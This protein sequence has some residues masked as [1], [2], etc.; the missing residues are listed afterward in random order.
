MP[1]QIET[2]SQ[3]DGFDSHQKIPFMRVL[4]ETDSLSPELVI[5]SVFK[6]LLMLTMFLGF[7]HNGNSRHFC[8][9]FPGFNLT[10]SSR[11][12]FRIRS[13]SRWKRAVESLSLIPGHRPRNG[14]FLSRIYLFPSIFNRQT[15]KVLYFASA[16]ETTGLSAETIAFPDPSKSTLTIK[17]FFALLEQKHPKLAQKKILSAVAVAINLEYID[18]DTATISPNDEVAIIPPVS[19]G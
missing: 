9:V 6:T 18:L 7:V 8:I 19:G 13:W 16:K 14:R 4:M 11:D 2:P 12:D 15:F 17:D 1:V 5:I 3:I 10:S